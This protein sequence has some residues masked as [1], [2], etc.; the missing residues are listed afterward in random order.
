[1]QTQATVDLHRR[2]GYSARKFRM[3]C[4]SL[5]R[6]Q[7]VQYVI[8]QSRA[9]IKNH[10]TPLHE[11]ARA[12]ASA[13]IP[14]FP[15]VEGGKEPAT[16]SSFKDATCDLAQIDEWW[17]QNPNY[18]LAFCPQDAGWC[19][20]DLDEGIVPKDGRIK[21]GIANWRLLAQNKPNTYV[22]R[23]PRGGQHWYYEGSLPP[24][25]G[26]IAQDVD[27]RGVGSYVLAPPS[28]VDGKPYEVLY[29]RDIAAVP[30][31]IV[32]ATQSRAVET[33]SA[34]N[35]LDLPSSILRVSSYLHDLVESG[36]T[37]HEGNGG[38]M[39]TFAVA[40]EA[41]NLGLS[42]EKA[43]ELIS[44]IWNPHCVP[45]WDEDEL[46]VKIENAAAYAQNEAGA[47]AVPPAAEA[48]GA[49]LDQ[50]AKSQPPEKRSRFHLED[51]DEQEDGKDPDWLLKDLMQEASTVMLVG[52]SGSGKSFIALDIA[53]GVAAKVETFGAV[54][55]HG[56]AIYAALEGRTNIKRARRRAWKI[57]RG[58]TAP[59]P[60]FF[61]T[62][63]PMIA[64]EGE[65][66]EFGDQIAKRCA[67][68]SPRIIILDTVAKCMA[69]MNENDA[70]DAGKFIRFCDSLV[71]AFQCVVVA[72]HHTGKDDSRGA[73][74]SSAFFAGFDTV[75]EVRAVGAEK[76]LEVFVRKHK[77]AEER[78]QPWTF[79]RRQIGPSLAFFPTTPEEHA[80]LTHP[81]DEFHPTNVGAALVKLGAYGVE[82]GVSTAVLASELLPAVE[83]EGV[84]Q[85]QVSLGLVSKKLGAISRTKLS[86]YKTVTGAGIVWHLPEKD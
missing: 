36:N 25:A 54:P 72:I 59:V 52:P 79:K 63:A 17:S 73:R 13:G 39:R 7:V 27:T 64:L 68:N 2:W 66:Q 71:E 6:P 24:S 41:L 81:V 70:Q 10:M 78:E 85:R 20:V 46:R 30:E 35:R 53:L 74:G 22:V 21:Q 28:I 49:A 29:E 86:A 75:I 33:A 43:H 8:P 48:F 44:E 40:C 34:D 4:Q 15:C 55:K 23:T 32:H 3:Y 84:E 76:A 67:G 31:W 42:Q 80:K 65:V 51:E 26:K 58:V 45:P 47:W 82:H 19:V 5:T 1:M 69:G 9:S 12:F 77:D 14:V 57:A 16:A 18:N 11:A 37:A 50:L 56:P 60:D 61:V 38:D 62:T 83:H